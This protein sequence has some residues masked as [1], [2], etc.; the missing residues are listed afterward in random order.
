MAQGFDVTLFALV[1]ANM[2]SSGCAKTVVWPRIL[3]LCNFLRN[4][5]T[6]NNNNGCSCVFLV[7][8]LLSVVAAPSLPYACRYRIAVVM[9]LTITTIVVAAA[10]RRLH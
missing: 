5:K 3:P 7:V 9:I 6:L 4:N 1:I 2:T 8:F 10:L